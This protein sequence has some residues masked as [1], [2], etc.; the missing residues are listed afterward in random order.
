[1]APDVELIDIQ[2]VNTAYKRV[3]NED[4]RFRYVIDMAS[5]KREMEAAA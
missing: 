2:D 1:V 5:L 3:K 4:V